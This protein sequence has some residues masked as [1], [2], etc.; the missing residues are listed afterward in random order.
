VLE[1]LAMDASTGNPLVSVSN[2][3]TLLYPP[4]GSGTSRLVWVSRQGVERSITE[5]ARRFAYPRLAPDGRRIVV[6]ADGGLW[7]QDSVRGGLTLLTSETTMGYN[8]A[9]VW[10]PD[11]NQVISRSRT[12]L[13]TIEVG[14]S[15]RVQS[16]SGSTEVS[17][18]PGS[19]SPDGK[20]LAFVRQSSETGGDIYVVDLRGDLKP[21]PWLMT[22][23]YEGGA[24]FS[25]DGRWMAYASDETGQMQVYLR[26]FP[27]PDPKEPVS[28]QGGTQPLWS[29]NG[30][31]LFYRNGNKM[32][33]VD[34]STSPH[35]VLSQPRQLFEQPYGFFTITIANYDVSLDGQS[36]LM[37]KD[38]SG[39]HRLNLVL[40]W[41]EEL[42][43]LVPTR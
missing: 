23:A 17:D 14:G 9:Q 37:V 43:R 27:G 34:V 4:S 7:V 35:L 40:N 13:R 26:P 38:E 18:I 3:G 21:R 22:P 12:G 39:S 10:T 20:T 42:K 2:A 30:K 33:A 24:Q 19:V 29:R 1:S 41:T 36:F 31:E 28:T 8:S 15:S 11:G 16:I 6:Y 25:P 5:A 32:M